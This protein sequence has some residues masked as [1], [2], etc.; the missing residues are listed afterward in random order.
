M[1]LFPT[2]PDRTWAA[3]H[4]APCSWG[5]A[6]SAVLWMLCGSRES[7][8]MHGFVAGNAQCQA[9][10]D[11]D[12]KFGMFGQGQNMVSV[13]CVA[14]LAAMLAGVAV[15]QEHGL[16]PIGKCA[17][18][19]AALAVCG[20]ATLPCRRP[21]A[22]KWF[23]AARPGAE[24]GALVS[25]IEHLAAVFALPCFGRIPNRPAR[26]RAVV[27]QICSVRLDLKQCSTLDARLS[28]LS[29]FHMPIMPHNTQLCSSYVAIER[30]ATHTGGTPELLP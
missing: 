7:S 15:T 21:F 1:T 16:A 19:L 24:T 9:V 13:H 26:F 27:R 25:A 3:V 6:V 14:L 11:I 2:V 5:A 29:I 30:W 20:L 28:H 12:G 18:V 22:N 23:T 17:F 8:A 4:R 10:G